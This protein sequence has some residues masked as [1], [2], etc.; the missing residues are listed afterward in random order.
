M[1][2]II[3]AHTDDVLSQAKALIEEAKNFMLSEGKVIELS[4]WLT[5][6]NYCN[7]YEIAE[8]SLVT[9]WIRRGIIPEEDIHVFP[10]FNNI[11]LIRDKK[12]K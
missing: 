9:N 3:N 12:Y 10:E 2:Q 4:D 5:I 6:K 11:R 1:V 8:E 7:K